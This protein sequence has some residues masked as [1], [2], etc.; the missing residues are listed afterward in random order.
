MTSKSEDDPVTAIKDYARRARRVR[1]ELD[2]VSR[3]PVLAV[4]GPFNSHD[5]SVGRT[6]DSADRERLVESALGSIDLN[7]ASR[8]RQVC[9]DL[10]DQSRLS[11]NGTA[12]EL[13]D[14]LANLL[15]TLAPDAE[16][17]SQGWYIQ[18]P[19]T[20]GP[21]Q[22]QRVRLVLQ[23]KKSNKNLENSLTKMSLIDELVSDLIRTTY[24]RG[25]SSAHTKS[26][27]R[28]C[29]RLIAYFDAFVLDLID[30]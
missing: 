16:C 17:T 22:K 27:W 8:Y 18:E 3:A 30:I 29:L 20:S 21:T 6:L 1:L 2:A 23:S 24:T 7:L 19:N 28:E 12:H 4:E 14:L 10:G 26:S 15:R 9:R 5:F 11:W 25:S 13:R